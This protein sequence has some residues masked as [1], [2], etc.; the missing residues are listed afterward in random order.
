MTIRVRSR[1]FPTPGGPNTG[2]GSL[3]DAFLNRA[4][5]DLDIFDI[6]AEETGGVRSESIIDAIAIFKEKRLEYYMPELPRP[7]LKNILYKLF[8]SGSLE[9]VFD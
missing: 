2:S 6:V 4:V 3:D 5:R 9:G 8:G 1:I 7:A